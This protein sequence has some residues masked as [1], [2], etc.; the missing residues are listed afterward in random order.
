MIEPLLFFGLIALSFGCWL[1]MSTLSSGRK[2][3]IARLTATLLMGAAFICPAV[4]ALI[5]IH[6][7]PSVEVTGRIQ[8]LVQ[9]HG[10]HSSST[11]EIE[12]VDGSTVLVY[13]DY[14]GDHLQNGEIAHATVLQYQ[15][16]LLA[17]HILDGSSSGWEI[18][19]GNGTV[20]AWLKIALGSFFVAGG[21]RKWR[22]D[23]DAPEIQ[24]DKTPLNGVDE[25]SLLHLNRE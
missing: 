18:Q 17:L 14:A 25:Q 5:M 23:P 9:L 24:D 10:K 1:W 22:L 21:I 13:A 11:F 20:S 15:N 3:G 2:R 8:N 19:E 12:S 6:R 16:T 7:S 4:V